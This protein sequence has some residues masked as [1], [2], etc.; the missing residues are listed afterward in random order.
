LLSIFQ[1]AARLAAV[2]GFIDLCL[3]LPAQTSHSVT[4][5]ITGTV[6]S[7]T[8]GNPNSNP[9]GG[10]NIFAVGSDLTGQ[11]FTLTINISD[12]DGT[13]NSPGTCPDGSIYSS[14][15]TGTSTSS[16]PSA[17]L[18]IGSTGRS[19]TY[20]AL[21]LYDLSWIMIRT[22]YSCYGYNT[23]TL[24]WSEYYNPPDAGGSG[25]G[26]VTLYTQNDLSPGY[27]YTPIPLQG[28]TSS[29]LPFTITVDQATNIS[30]TLYYAHGLLNPTSIEMSESNTTPSAQP[31]ILREG[32][33][34]ITGT[35]QSV[36]VGQRIAL[37]ASLP[38]GATLA[39]GQPWTV[40]GTTI[41]GFVV[42]TVPRSPLRGTGQA[43]NPDF[44]QASTVFYWVD[45]GTFPVTLSCTLANGQSA[46]AQVTFDVAPPP[47]ASVSSSVG[48]VSI[49]PG[50]IDGVL[51][52]N[53][54]HLYR[55]HDP[56]CDLCGIVFTATPTIAS[57]AYVWVQLID[58]DLLLA[59]TRRGDQLE[60]EDTMGGELDNEYPYR[61]LIS[62]NV[63]WD[64]PETVLT[65]GFSEVNQTFKARMFLMWDPTIPNGCTPG[66][67]CTS[68]PIPLGYVSWQFS[69]DA[70]QNVTWVVRSSDQ[71]AK[72][73]QSSTGLPPT[74][75]YPQW[76]ATAENG[77]ASCGPSRGR[78]P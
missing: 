34:D 4:I 16:P 40:L 71:S 21:P 51:E 43:I 53:I 73:F 72:P 37:T 52:D 46:Q 58:E 26:N 24:G 25:F 6:L 59:T 78:R 14:A 32:T 27:W 77:V 15:I 10:G 65:A 50:V 42:T 49:D 56:Q 75:T 62:N 47:S 63:A 55:S 54:L 28:A 23:V 18:Q 39:A 57:G 69:A 31:K 19:F 74:L 20:G 5:I 41:G 36:V 7:G 8:D 67:T 64:G 35:T 66:R 60:C 12:S 17:R 3:A 33:T 44:T 68:I 2:V 38:A 61:G 22:S 29:P 76:S 30:N 9:P 11:P 1:Y 70:V 13:P 45:P 48:T